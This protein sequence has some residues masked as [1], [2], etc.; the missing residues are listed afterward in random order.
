MLAH[1]LGLA[2]TFS[3]WPPVFARMPWGWW[4]VNNGAF[5]LMLAACKRC[6][7]CRNKSHSKRAG[8]AGMSRIDGSGR[9]SGDGGNRTHV[10]D[11]AQDGVYER[12]R[13]SVSRPPLA[14][15]AGLKGA[16]L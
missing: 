1:D 11:R 8:F 2:A 4:L 9:T 12:I 3:S 6:H 16:S 10:R 15:P 5:L 7:P 14:T 13:R